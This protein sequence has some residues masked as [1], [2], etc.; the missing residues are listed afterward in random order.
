MDLKKTLYPGLRPG[1]LS[2]VPAG[3]VP[4]HPD[5]WFVFNKRCPKELIEKANFDKSVRAVQMS[6]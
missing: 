5:G 3:L 4:T 1:L 2:I 6:E